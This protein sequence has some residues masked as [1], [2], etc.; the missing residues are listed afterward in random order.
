MGALWGRSPSAMWARLYLLE[1]STESW[2][3]SLSRNLHVCKYLAL[4]HPVDYSDSMSIQIIGAISMVML[5]I[6][7]A[8]GLG[9]HSSSLDPHQ[10][11]LAVMY[12]W[13]NI[14]FA[15]IAIGLGKIAIIVFILHIQGYYE[16]WRS[17]F[18][19]FMGASTL[20][21]NIVTVILIFTQCLPV[22]VIWETNIRGSCGRREL[23]K[24]FGIFQTC[25]FS[26]CMSLTPMLTLDLGLSA[27]SAFCDL[28]LALYPAFLFWNIQTFSL[29]RKIGI[30]VL[31]GL[32]VG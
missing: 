15:L 29:W 17:A 24:N 9:Q 20:G 8:H 26:T 22:Q 12:G 31:F 32:G 7:A 16:P 13:I 14:A 6:G 28:A 27:W 25:E 21:I 3:R 10:A 4:I 30:S 2:G 23:V 18:L 1:D 5:T 19:W 11:H